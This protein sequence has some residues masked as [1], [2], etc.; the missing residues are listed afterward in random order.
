MHCTCKKKCEDFC[1]FVNK[2]F[3]ALFEHVYLQN[4]LLRFQSVLIKYL[5]GKLCK[6][7][8]RSV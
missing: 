2:V 4:K 6:L 1:T 8:S 7:H 3:L 5:G